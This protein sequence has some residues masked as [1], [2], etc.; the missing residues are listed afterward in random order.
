[1]D[2]EALKIA[3]FSDRYRLTVHASE[4]M[5][6]DELVMDE[7]INSM[8]KGIVIEDYPK[9]KPFPSCLVLGFGKSNFPI[10]MVWAYKH[11][12]NE[13]TLVTVYRPDPKKWVEYK[14]RRK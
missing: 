12:A 5:E 3:I 10:H 6:S 13:A 8:Y 9:S 14:K 4:E 2:L 1:M 11:S 7:I